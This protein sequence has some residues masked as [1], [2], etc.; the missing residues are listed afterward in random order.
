MGLDKANPPNSGY[1]AGEGGLLL[2]NII[3][4]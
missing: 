2:D 3:I 1:L 4:I